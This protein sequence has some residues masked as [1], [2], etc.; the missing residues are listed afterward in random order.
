MSPSILSAAILPFF[1]S[2]W[3]E[4]PISAPWWSVERMRGVYFLI[5]VRSVVW[6]VCVCCVKSS[7][8]ILFISL[9]SRRFSVGR[10]PRSGHARH[11][12]AILG[13]LAFLFFRGSPAAL[14]AFL[15][16]LRLDNLYELWNVSLGISLL[17]GGGR[18][19]QALG[20]PTAARQT[21]S[22]GW[23][24]RSA[25]E[26]S[27]V[28][29]LHGRFLLSSSWG[30]EQLRHRAN[31]F[32]MHRVTREDISVGTLGDGT[33]GRRGGGGFTAGKSIQRGEAPWPRPPAGWW[34]DAP[35]PGAALTWRRVPNVQRLWGRGGGRGGFGEV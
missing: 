20:A 18:C 10:R 22:R 11:G 13:A 30:S 6:V 26:K 29:L 9:F 14:N 27:P 28:A 7:R 31:S 19:V 5:G 21:L 17:V 1:R 3:T 15:C 25:R 12:N 16:V 24:V 32:Q 8:C 2:R 23:F 33:S 4:V 34:A 35:L